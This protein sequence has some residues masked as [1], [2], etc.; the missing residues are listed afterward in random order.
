M[1]GNTKFRTMRLKR[2]DLQKLK[3]EGETREIELVG[4]VYA[5]EDVTPDLIEQTI[6]KARIHGRIIAT[7]GVRQA[8]LS[9]EAA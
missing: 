9:R 2:V 4:L 6:S 1:I 8:L 3:D 7:P 5:D